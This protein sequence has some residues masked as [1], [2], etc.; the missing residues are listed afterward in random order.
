MAAL[1][2]SLDFNYSKNIAVRLQPDLILEH[3]GT[4]TREFFAISAGIVYRFGKVERA[5]QTRGPSLCR[6]YHPDPRTCS[7]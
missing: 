5:Q 6:R 3:F 7:A 1:G 2:D 4:E